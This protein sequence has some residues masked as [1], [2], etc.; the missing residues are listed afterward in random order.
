V[1]GDE[2]MVLDEPR[3]IGQRLRLA[4]EE[5]GLSVKELAGKAG[6]LDE[7]LQWVEDGQIEPPV[8]LLIQLARALKLESGTFIEVDD[9][10]DR[11][12]KEAAK[13]TEHYSYKTLTAPE[14]DSHLM[15]FSVTIPVKTAHKG[16]GYQHEGEEFVYVLSGE[17]EITVDK[18]TT[19]LGEKQSL[20]FNSS[21]DH[22]LA[23]PGERES[24][25]LVILY[26]P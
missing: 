14:A 13:R 8:A 11:R 6:C 18:K 12:L 9:F 5:R 23:N 1:K 15:A 7:Y 2:K 3:P 16:V 22:H 19:R 20:R 4:R 26:L 25:L 24:E 21:H 17:V 10:S